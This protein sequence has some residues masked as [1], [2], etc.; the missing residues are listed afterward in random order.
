VAGAGH[1]GPRA[2]LGLRCLAYAVR[3]HQHG[4]R[5]CLQ[6]ER[7]F[8]ALAASPLGSKPLWTDEIA[9]PD[10]TNGE[11]IASAVWN[12]TDGTLY[13]A[14]G[15]TTIRGTGYR[16]S[17]DKINPAT[18]AYVWQTGL[19]CRVIG[20]PTLDS[21][22][23]L[24]VGTTACTAPNTPGAYLINAATGAVLTRLPVGSTKVFGQPVFAQGTLFVATETNGLYDL[25]P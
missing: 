10:G 22:G 23:V 16:G 25:A 19:P 15:F 12:A 7:S 2:W 8:Y 3:Q 4:R 20:T 9:E 11:C 14:G 24:A 13:A 5:R 6:Q 1:C 17:I 18:G 21:A